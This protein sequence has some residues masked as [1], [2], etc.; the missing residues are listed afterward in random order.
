LQA[1]L[2]DASTFNACDEKAVCIGVNNLLRMSIVFIEINT[3][4]FAVKSFIN[5]KVFL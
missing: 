1:D 2:P 4:K 3:G 5:Q